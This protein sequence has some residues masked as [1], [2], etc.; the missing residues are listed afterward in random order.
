MRQILLT[1]I[2]GA[3]LVTGMPKAANAAERDAPGSATTKDAGTKFGTLDGASYR[4]D[5]PPN[6]NRGLVVYYHGY[7]I[8]SQEFNRGEP[9][10][11]MFTPL[12][13][14]GYA[15]LQSGYSA[16]GWAVE[17]AYA[18]TEKLR[19]KFI[20]DHG[21]PTRSFVVGMSMGGTLTVMTI[22]Q[23]AGSY[24]GAL[25]L[26]GV[27]EATD[28]F[29]QHDFALRAAFD[30]YFPGVLG[31]LVPIA[32]DYR[33]D[34]AIIGKI[35]AALASNPKAAN[36]LLRYYGVGDLD[37]LGPVL[38]FISYD[39]M[40]LQQRAG[41]NPFDNADLVYTGSGD[42]EALNDGVSRYRSDP[43]AR[44][45]ALK[46]YTPTGQLKKPMLALH[47]VGDPLVDA[48]TAFEYAMLAQRAGNGDRFVQQY[49]KRDGHCVFQPDEI[50][51]A[52]DQLVRWVD[53]GHRPR[54]GRQP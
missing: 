2:A 50:A 37:D 8:E 48:K 31:P 15:V 20:K 44:A 5:I 21:K 11:P 19:Q 13:Q 12:L 51:R 1:L 7:E 24:D 40:E 10:S 34:D 49:V 28:R 16:A 45:Y 23:R 43:K 9:I 14:R 6:W 3:V 26:C 32:K 52:F 29:M 38:A 36:A 17:Q 54:S 42:D 33:P 47:N 4:I 18:D 22:E 25:S 41:G 53:N 39:T 35:N 30:F 27:L 46:W